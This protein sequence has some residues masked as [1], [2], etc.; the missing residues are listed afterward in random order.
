MYEHEAWT[1]YM[2]DSL[3]EEYMDKYGELDCIP[4]KW[5]KRAW[6]YRDKDAY[7]VVAVMPGAILEEGKEYLLDDLVSNCGGKHTPLIIG[8]SVTL[9]DLEDR[10]HPLPET[11]GRHDLFFAFHDLDITRVAVPRL[12]YGIRWWSD[13]VDNEWN[14][15]PLKHKA[16]YREHTIYPDYVFESIG[17][18]DGV[19][20][21]GQEEE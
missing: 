4:V 9:P 8:T 5:N 11:G 14:K 12:A 21:E 13:V 1:E 3:E 10:D 7:S 16:N 2:L 20:D 17:Y 19:Y 15:M 6:K 18:G